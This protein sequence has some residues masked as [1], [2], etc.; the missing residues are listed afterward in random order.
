LIEYIGR[1]GEPEAMNIPALI[2]DGCREQITDHGNIYWTVR[3]R[4]RQRESSP[5]LASHKHPCYQV[6]EALIRHDYPLDEGWSGPLSNEAD[7]FLTHLQ[8]NFWHAFADDSAGTYHEH[9]L[10][11]PR[12]EAPS[13]LIARLRSAR[14]SAG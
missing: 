6:V 11:Q 7:E 13:D 3:W 12:S 4:E 9:R 14:A 1:D 8:N 10:V 5:L 2:C